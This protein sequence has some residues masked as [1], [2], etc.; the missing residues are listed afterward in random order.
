MSAPFLL[1][2]PFCGGK[3]YTDRSADCTATPSVG[4]EDCGTHNVA[5]TMGEAIIKWNARTS[6]PKT[7]PERNNHE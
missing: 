3:A 4:C 1:P 2:C 5:E 6:R 7:F